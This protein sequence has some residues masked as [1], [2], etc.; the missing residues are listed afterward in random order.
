MVA[1]SDQKQILSNS[2]KKQVLKPKSA[3]I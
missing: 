1:L 2:K 3:I